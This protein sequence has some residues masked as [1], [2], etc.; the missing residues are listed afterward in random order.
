MQIGTSDLRNKSMKRPIHSGGQPVRRSKVK[1]TRGRRLIWRP[2]EGIIF[3]SFGR[4]AF[5]VYAYASLD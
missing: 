5:L 4:V 3:D 1:V 2:G